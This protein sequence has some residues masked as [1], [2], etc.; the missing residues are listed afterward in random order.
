[1][2]DRKQDESNEGEKVD[3]PGRLESAKQTRKKRIGRRDRGDM[4]KPVTTTSGNATNTT[5]QYPHF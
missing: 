1:V 5:P 4:A 3:R 2:H